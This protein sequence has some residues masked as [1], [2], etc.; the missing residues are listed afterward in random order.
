MAKTINY[1]KIYGCPKHGT[2]NGSK[3]VL[4]T[5]NNGIEVKKPCYRCE[6]CNKVYLEPDKGMMGDTKRKVQNY[7]IW[8]TVGPFPL[9]G[10]VYLYDK[11]TEKGCCS[12]PGKIKKKTKTIT[13]VLLKNGNTKSLPGTKVCLHCN[14]VFITD[15]IYRSHQKFFDENNITVINYAEDEI[16]ATNHNDLP[17]TSKNKEKKSDHEAQNSQNVAEGWEA[18]VFDLEDNQEMEAENFA[19]LVPA[20]RVA[21][22]YYDAKISYNPYQ[23]LPWLK[24]F[25]NGSQ[26][27]LISDEVGLGKTI[28]AGILIMEELTENVNARIVVLCPAFLREK[29]YQELN[30]KFLLDAQI[31]DGKTAIDSMTNIVILPISRIKQYLEREGDFNYTMVTIDEVHYFKN[32]SSARYG[33]LREF[34]DKNG[35]CKKVFMSATPVSNSGNDYHSIERLFANKPDRTNTTK[36]QAYIYLPDRNVEDVYVKL[37]EPEQEFYDTTDALDPFSGTI[38]RHIGASCLYALSKYAYSGNE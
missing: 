20:N 17:D 32:S 37:T 23:Y 5:N 30:E 28:E 4:K 8:N 31:Y 19:K 14:K 34:L 35:E 3:A 25:V 33:Y 2:T 18:E 26:R 27:I 16:S 11:S 10:T 12:C 21:S 36:K 7:S 29:W 6:T 1:R 13:H 22:A 24:M 15:G 38:Y 9:H